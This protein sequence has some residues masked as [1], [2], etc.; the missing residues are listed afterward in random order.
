MLDPLYIIA[1]RKHLL[2]KV[3]RNLKPLSSL[4]VYLNEMRR[5]LS[6]LKNQHHN[7]DTFFR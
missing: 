4:T 2:Y 7:P 1:V 3:I 6:H 5:I